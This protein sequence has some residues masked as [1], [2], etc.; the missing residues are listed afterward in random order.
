MNVGENI[1]IA[2][3][4]LAAN[5][6]RAILTM[7]GIMIGG[8]GFPVLVDLFV[9]RG[10]RRRLT[11]HSKLTLVGTAILLFAG[12]AMVLAFEWSNPDTLGPLDVPD[13]P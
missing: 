3:R 8:L 13:P 5:K 11:M 2:L 7:L 12:L 9:H 10:S 1:R 6:L 4:A